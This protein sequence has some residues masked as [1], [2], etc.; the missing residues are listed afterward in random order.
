MSTTNEQ[1]KA[2]GVYDVIIVGCGHAG[3]E[4]ALASARLGLKTL[5]VTISMDNIGM[6]PCNPSI[7]GPAK[8]HLVREIDALGGEMGRNIDKTS[9]QMRLLNTSKGP[10][11]YSLRA[12]ADKYAYKQEMTRT[13]QNTENLSVKQLIVTKLII[14]NNSVK[15]IVSQTGMVYLASA[16]VLTTGTYLKSRIII[17]EYAENCGPNGQLAANDLSIQ[18]KEL[19]LPIVRFKTGTPARVDKRTLDFTKMSRQDA[20]ADEF[21]S[22]GTKEKN[23]RPLVPCWLT[24]TNE[25]THRIITANLDRAPMYSGFIKGTGPRYC[26][27]IEDK[28]VRFSDKSRHQLFIESEGLD[29]E[30]MYVQ[31]LS[32]SLPEE[33]QLQFLRTIPGLEKAEIMR[34][35]Y[36]IEYDCVD[37]LSLKASLESKIIKGLFSAGQINGTSGYEEAAAQGLIAGINAARFIKNLEPIILKRYEGYIGVLIDD[38]V[39]KGTNEPYRMLTSRAEYRLILREDN[40]DLRLSELGHEI[41]LLGEERYNEFCAKR[42]H[43]EAEIERLNHLTVRADSENVVNFLA[44]KSA[45]PLRQGIPASEFLKRPEV[46]YRDLLNLGLGDE[47]LTRAEYEQVEIQIKYA[48]YIAKQLQ[49]VSRMEKLENK[50]LSADL[51]YNDISGLRLEARQKLSKIKPH[52][53]GQASRISGVSPADIGV[54]MVYL[55]QQR[56]GENHAEH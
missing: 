52:T 43:I 6:M 29:T 36:A 17:G 50:V 40:A 10:A 55:E 37:P 15:G 53:V 21:F 7:G 32:S 51:D 25:E 9:I 39:T 46:T 31:G 4:A 45:S 49:Q 16:V 24:Y 3:C 5:A 14:E 34:P 30:E 22:F 2:A 27:S 56:R 19:G 18:L 33:I 48:G 13:L 44:A 38:L 42:A 26:P 8:S 35:A 41:G 1:T 28:V 47:T 12:Q 23:G 20:N 11:V 54:L